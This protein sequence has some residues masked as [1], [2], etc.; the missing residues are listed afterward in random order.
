MPPPT[1]FL[2]L[3][4][5]M[6]G[7]MPVVSQSI[8]KAMVPVGAST[9]AWRCGSRA[10]SPTLDASSQA[11]AAACS[12]SS[13]TCAGVDRFSRVAVLAH[14]AQDRLA[15]VREARERALDGGDP[16]RLS[17]GLAAHQRGDR[18]GVGAALVRVVGQPARHQQR[19]EVGVAEA[20]RTVVV[21][22]LR[23]RRRRVGGVVDQ[24]LLRRDHHVDGVPEAST[25]NARSPGRSGHQVQRGQVAGRVVEEHVL[26]ARVRG[27][28]RRGVRAGVPV[29]DRGVELHAG[30]AADPGGAGHLPIRSRALIGLHRPAGRHRAGV[31]SPSLSTAR[32]NSSVDAHRVVGVLEEHRIVG[33][34][35][36]VEL[37][38]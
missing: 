35:R 2:Y 21:G 17:V 33:A 11:R 22:V 4:S 30:I 28:D 36:H 1:S 8:M 19:A 32:M 16:R 5:A 18:G 27:V 34:A 14:D 13:G 25:S 6:S 38:V 31:Q 37:A 23:D 29:V 9:V 26:G 7:S 3:T 20:Q 15:V 10:R 24:D 12:S